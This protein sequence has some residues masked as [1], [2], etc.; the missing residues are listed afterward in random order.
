ML[1][2]SP[3]AIW[4]C[5]RSQRLCSWQRAHAAPAMP[6]PGCEVSTCQ[7]CTD[8]QMPAYMVPL[9]KLTYPW[10]PSPYTWGGLKFDLFEIELACQVRVPSRGSMSLHPSIF[11]S[12]SLYIYMYNYI[13]ICITIYYIHIYMLRFDPHRLCC[14]V[15]SESPRTFPDSAERQRPSSWSCAVVASGCVLTS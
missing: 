15:H 10:L 4:A 1:R 6:R 8:A 13:Y 3:D 11:L 12:L 7:S 2:V 5:A 9:G 14:G